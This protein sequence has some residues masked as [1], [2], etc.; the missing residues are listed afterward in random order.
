MKTTQ[1]QHHTVALEELT[2]E[3]DLAKIEEVSV[4]LPATSRCAQCGA[5]AYVEVE[6]WDTGKPH[7]NFG[8]RALR[9][10]DTAKRT[11][12][13][14]AH[15]YVAHESVLVMQAIRVIDHRPFL[16]LQERRFKGVDAR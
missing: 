7:L 11:L 9:P 13:F 12:E 8:L 10:G 5:Q 1:P 4:G 14:C 16:R 6:V 15:H 3:P 2:G